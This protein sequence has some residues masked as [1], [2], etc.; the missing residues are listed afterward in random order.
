MRCR[1]LLF[2]LDGVL[3]DSRACV[4][5]VWRAWA[6]DRNIDVGEMIRV[7]QGRRTSETLRAIAPHLDVAA[8]VARLDALEEQATDGLLA[9]PGAATLL[10]QL[11]ADQWAIVTSCSRSVA[12]LRLTIAGL[13]I[14]PVFVTGDQV[15][16]GKPDPQGYLQ[17]ADLLRVQPAESLVLE[18]AP[19]GI[20]AARAAG[21]MVIGL[22]T[23][24]AVDAIAHADIV[25]SGFGALQIAVLPDGWIEVGSEP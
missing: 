20:A 14:P 23:T 16:R 8:E 2:D 12:T 7:G 15:D 3:V 6:V 1:A 11:R 24:H 22:A 21:M 18:D 17:A 13:P 9:A 5:R 10:G 4:E 25:V 19:V